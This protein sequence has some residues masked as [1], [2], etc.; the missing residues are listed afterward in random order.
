MAKQKYKYPNNLII[1]RQ[2]MRFTQAQV[3]HLLGHGDTKRISDLELGKR[4]PALQTSLRLAIIYRVPVDFLYFEMYSSYR[5]QIRA[6]ERTLK[7]GR[8]GSLF[9]GE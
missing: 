8:Q 2:R 9:G 5:D 1:Y 4:L 6:R 7:V 3:A